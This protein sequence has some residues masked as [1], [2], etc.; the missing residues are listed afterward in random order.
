LGK[1]VLERVSRFE[2]TS[3]LEGGYGVI[4]TVKKPKQRGNSLGLFDIFIF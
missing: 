4:L 1:R 2:S 3:V